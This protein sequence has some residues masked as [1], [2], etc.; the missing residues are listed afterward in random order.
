MRGGAREICATIAAR[1]ENGHVR[2]EAV[3]FA[4][5]HV[6]GDDAA[7]HAVLHDQVDREVLD[8]KRRGMTDRLLI[9]GVEHRVTGT[10]RR[11]AGPLRNSLAKVGGH[12]TERPLVNTT[13]L[14]P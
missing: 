6:D 5:R 3:N 11:R 2:T 13:L 10:V 4:F 1:G 7:A 14:G 12:T 8:E 9:Q